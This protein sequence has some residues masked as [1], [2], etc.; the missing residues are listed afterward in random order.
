ML[1]LPVEEAA[2]LMIPMKLARWS[3]YEYDQL[4]CLCYQRPGRLSCRC[5]MLFCSVNWITSV[6]PGA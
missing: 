5:D 4:R 6:R 1:S 2:K 3:L